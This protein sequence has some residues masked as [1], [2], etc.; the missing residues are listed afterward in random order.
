MPSIL[1]II[2]ML[3]AVLS[4]VI[5]FMNFRDRRSD[6]AEQDLADKIKADLKTSILADITLETKELQKQA[7]ECEIKHAILEERLNNEIDLLEKV[8]KK[9]DA[10]ARKL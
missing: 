8:E 3:V 1:E 2:A 5:A 6:K 9:I 4:L 7:N 10:I